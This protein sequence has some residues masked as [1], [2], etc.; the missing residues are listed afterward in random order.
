MENFKTISVVYMVY[1]ADHHPHTN[2][3]TQRQS[4]ER[5]KKSNYN[6]NNSSKTNNSQ[7][8]MKKMGKNTQPA[9]KKNIFVWWYNIWCIRI[10]CAPCRLRTRFSV[11]FFLVFSPYFCFVLF[12]FLHVGSYSW[13][14]ECVFF[15]YRYVDGK[16]QYD[17]IELKNTTIS[18]KCCSLKYILWLLTYPAKQM[19]WHGMKW[20]QMEWNER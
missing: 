16:S 12:L 18:L 8:K 4:N 6:T 9:R 17:S 20:K 15:V 7:C 13:W 14:I 10:G 19:E 11:I 5:E 2:Q 3:C 1:M